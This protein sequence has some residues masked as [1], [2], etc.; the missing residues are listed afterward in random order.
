MSSQASRVVLR[1][2]VEDVLRVELGVEVVRRM[3]PRCGSGE[4][5]RPVVP[6][7][8]AWVSLAYADGAGL[9]AWSRAGPVGVDLEAGLDRGDWTRREAL[10]KA[11]GQG[12]HGLDAPLPDLLVAA[13]TLPPPYVGHVAGP[14]PQWRLV[15]P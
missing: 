8:D 5:G 6:L 3:C 2:L 4:H 12:V 14:A 11:T 9:A 10:L 13:L 7:A 15:Q 1:P